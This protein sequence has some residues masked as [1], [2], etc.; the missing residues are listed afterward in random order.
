M[1]NVL[2]I[3][4]GSIAKKHIDNL[5]NLGFRIYVFTSNNKFKE[6]NDKIKKIKN[7]NKIPKILFAIIAN[8]TNNHLKYIE[9]L[10][11]KKN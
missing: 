10:I 1:D 9:L 8:S 2:V 5:Y 11:K 4:S 7:L 3:G 6:K